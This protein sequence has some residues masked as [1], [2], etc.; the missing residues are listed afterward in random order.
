[1]SFACLNNGKLSKRQRDESRSCIRA[2]AAVDKFALASNSYQRNF[3][4][5]ALGL[6][7]AYTKTVR[8]YWLARG[9]QVKI[10][11]WSEHQLV[12]NS[13]KSAKHL[14]CPPLPF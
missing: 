5:R 3:N 12:T 8:I 11:I 10:R 7:R 4:C 14:V 1:M 2:L 9:S 6:W 13:R